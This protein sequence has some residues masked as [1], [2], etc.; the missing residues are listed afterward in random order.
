MARKRKDELLKDVAEF[1]RSGGVRLASIEDIAQALGVARS[2]LYYHFGS[3]GDMVYEILCHNQ[4]LIAAKL[5]EVYEFPLGATDRLTLMIRAVVQLEAELPSLGLSA[6]F[7]LDPDLLTREQRAAYVAK[8]DAYEE[9][10][11]SVIREGAEAGEFREVEARIVTFGILGMLT[12]FV[13]WYRPGG[14]LR[15]TEIAA[16]FT[17][18]VL[19]G[20]RAEPVASATKPSLRQ[21]RAEA[22]AAS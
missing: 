9:L 13:N 17:E 20:L 7:R 6:V 1:F 22:H 12:E 3:R 15:P 18:L 11:R 4:D 10:F 2:A 14:A 19:G 21:E 8:R 5:R 16:I